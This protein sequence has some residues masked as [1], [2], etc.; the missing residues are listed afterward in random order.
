MLERSRACTRMS[1]LRLPASIRAVSAAIAKASAC[2]NARG[3]RADGGPVIPP[4]SYE[5]DQPDGEVTLAD[6]KTIAFIAFYRDARRA[7]RLEP[8]IAA[9]AKHLGGEIERRGTVTLLW[10]RPPSHDLR[11]D[12]RACAPQ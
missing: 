2:L 1:R 7:R 3:R 4:D 10:T 9:N 8:A 12:M 6:G 11:Q 5:G